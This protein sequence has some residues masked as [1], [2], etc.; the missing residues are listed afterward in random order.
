MYESSCGFCCEAGAAMGVIGSVHSNYVHSRR[1]KALTS[2]LAAMIPPNA[3]VLDVGCGDGKLARLLLD[4]RPDLTLQGVD[5]LVRPE[6]LVPVMPFDGKTL[7]VEDKSFDVVM[8][9]DVL[10]HT[11]DPMSLL[12]EAV[13]VARQAVV[14]KDHTKTG[15]L[16]QPVLQFMDYVGNARHGVPS[17]GNYWTLPQWKEAFAELG[18]APTEWKSE[19]GLYPWWA[20]WLFGH[21]LHFLASL[22][23]TVTTLQPAVEP[24][25]LTAQNQLAPALI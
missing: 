1:V 6:T 22:G 14:I 18:I 2:H 4:E 23:R 10:H 25:H 8:F 12:R 9:V 19:L 24:P 17:P 20:N 15:L 13:R 7:P 3:S 16:G 5:V 11:H 21:N